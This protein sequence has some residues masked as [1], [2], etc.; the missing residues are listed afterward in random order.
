MFGSK[1][2]R[3]RLLAMA[4]VAMFAVCA[5]VPMVGDDSDANPYGGVSG[6]YGDVVNGR[7]TIPISVGQAFNYTPTTNFD[8]VYG[9]ITY[10][11]T[12]ND[13]G[14]D[15]TMAD[16]ATGAL[17][18]TFDAD[19]AGTEVTET[20]T[21]TWTYTPEGGDTV[22]QIATQEITFEIDAKLNIID[23][24]NA[25]AQVGETE[26][27]VVIT[28]TGGAD[29]T[30]S[31]T[32]ATDVLNVAHDKDVKKITITAKDPAT[33]TEGKYTL[34]LTLRNGATG[35]EDSIVINVN[36]YEDLVVTVSKST[37][38]TYEGAGTINPVTYTINYEGTDA[39]VTETVTSDT[40][41]DKE[42][43]YFEFDTTLNT[44][45]ADFSKWTWD[46]GNIIQNGT[47]RDDQSATF[48]VTV[49]AD[50]TLPGPDNGATGTA[51]LTDTYSAEVEYV[52][53]KSFQFTNTPT[54]G[55]VN[56]SAIATGSGTMNL[57]AYISGAK[58]VTF[59]WGDGTVSELRTSDVANTYAA[60]HTYSKS[61]MYMITI[62]ATNDVGTTTSKVLYQSGEGM[63]GETVEGSDSTGTTDSTNKGFFDE[64]GYLFLVFAI[65]AL[66]SILVFL[67]YFNHPAMIVIAIVALILAAALY[68]Y[69]DF[70]GVI[71]ALKD[72]L[73]IG[74]K[75]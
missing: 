24:V 71:D 29:V 21:A 43:D 6:N 59:N 52:V 60:N 56:A 46:A 39:T 30:E 37:V 12:G 42:S 53:F 64:H 15:I 61:G 63:V 22:T 23:Q 48:T 62:T 40:K 75:A 54:V 19:V 74:N 27:I 73:G 57:S 50:A 65:I 8:D 41:N 49:K 17:S 72:V 10:S 5:L 9:D 36:I 67:F 18:G 45:N 11:W 34:N 4:V 16:P 33:I 13:N 44:I 1:Q 26:N 58:S 35:D 38:Y 47:Y 69:V 2:S 68:V 55:T 25:Y 31:F 20:L 14:C 3:T 28:Y 7:Y 70:T 32:G 66:A 51:T